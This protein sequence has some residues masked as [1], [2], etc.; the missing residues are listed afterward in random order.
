[1]TPFSGIKKGVLKLA[2]K[3]FV[4][5]AA[6]LLGIRRDSR[7]VRAESRLRAALKDKG[8][9]PAS[10]MQVEVYWEP[11]SLSDG[12]TIDTLPPHILERLREANR[13]K[14]GSN[15]KFISRVME[16]LSAKPAMAEQAVESIEKALD[17]VAA[18]G[19]S[20]RK[21]IAPLYSMMTEPLTSKIKTPED[22]LRLP[23]LMMSKSA[24]YAEYMHEHSTNR[25]PFEQF[26]RPAITIRG[27]YWRSVKLEIAKA[28]FFA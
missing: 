22:I 2:A 24:E 20:A 1:M 8:I 27:L 26:F 21:I 19:Y 25:K 15:E 9:S 16:I 3:P 14:Y 23:Q 6:A 11:I 18:A 12:Q 4:V 5:K 7:I 13:K 28:L 10:Q 17:Q